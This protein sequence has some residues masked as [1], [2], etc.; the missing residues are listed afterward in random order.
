LTVGRLK[1]ESW[2]LDN[3]VGCSSGIDLAPL[4]SRVSGCHVWPNKH[5][6]TSCGGGEQRCQHTQANLHCIGFS[7]V[8]C[9]LSL[10]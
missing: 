9:N 2:L 7:T 4:C 5:W 6:D 8:L 1:L 3:R 10:A